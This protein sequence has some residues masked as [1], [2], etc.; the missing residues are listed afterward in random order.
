MKTP[1]EIKRGAELCANGAD[2]G[3]CMKVCPYHGGEPGLYCF[4]AL[5]KDNLAYIRDLEARVAELEKP[6]KPM[7]LERLMEIYN[8]RANHSWPLNTPPYFIVES[9]N[10]AREF[11][12]WASWSDIKLMLEHSHLRYNRDNYGKTWRCWPRRPTE[13]ERKA[14]EW[15]EDV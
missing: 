4:E 9:N 5:A 14:A 1:D 11:C 6:L 2:D 7:T 3:S 12:G 15:D 8:D 10:E 13:E